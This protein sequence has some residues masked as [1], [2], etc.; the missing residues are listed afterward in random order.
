MATVDD[1]RWRPDTFASKP[2]RRDEPSASLGGTRPFYNAIRRNMLTGIIQEPTDGTL[3]MFEIFFI[4]V[5]LVSAMGF[6]IY[7]LLLA[8]APQPPS[9]RVD[10][11]DDETIAGP[12][13]P[14][15]IVEECDID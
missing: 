9:I 13:R 3:T 8:P 4:T 2:V 1:E 11:S 7:A 6:A 10:P 14:L 15:R 5:A 12:H